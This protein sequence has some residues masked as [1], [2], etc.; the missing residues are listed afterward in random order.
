[1]PGVAYSRGKYGPGIYLSYLPDGT[2]VAWKPLSVGE[3]LELYQ[4]QERGIIPVVILEEEIFRKCVLDQGLQFKLDLLPAGTVSTI[5]KIIFDASG[6]K[7]EQDLSHALDSARV[8]AKHVLHTLVPIICQIFPAYTPEILYH[9]DF[10]TFMLRLAQAESRLLAMG[11]IQEPI[12]FNDTSKPE[13]QAKS[14]RNLKKA[15]EQAYQKTPAAPPVQKPRATPTGPQKQVIITDMDAEEHAAIY[16]GHEA[17]DRIII[18]HEMVQNTSP[19]YKDYQ[20]QIRKG[21]KVRIKT[22]EERIAE[23]KLRMVANK[24][25]YQKKIRERSKKNETLSELIEKKQSKKRK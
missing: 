6:P 13:K 5:A 10:E 2:E 19:I 8:V 4:Q 18:E 17:E 12:S 11:I 7:N 20:E 1:M 3:Y 25:A 16:T 24:T 22:V 9:L 14:Q 21:E 23:A 15:W